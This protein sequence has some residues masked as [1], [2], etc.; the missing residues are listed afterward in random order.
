[1]SIAPPRWFVAFPLNARPPPKKEH[2][3]L[4]TPLCLSINPCG[5]YVR[6]THSPTSYV[7]AQEDSQMLVQDEGQYRS[8]SKEI[9]PWQE[10]TEQAD[11][12]SPI[13]QG[14]ALEDKQGEYEL[15]GNNL[16]DNVIRAANENTPQES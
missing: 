6:A 14:V 5:F 10:Q 8:R 15:S 3:F 1:M 7:Q 11:E 9:M 13:A 2:S 4:A 12:I 16:Q